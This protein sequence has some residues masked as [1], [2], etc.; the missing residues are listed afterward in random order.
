MH[1][2]RSFDYARLPNRSIRDAIAI[3]K[4]SLKIVTA[5]WTIVYF[6]ILFSVVL[7]DSRWLIGF[8]AEPLFILLYLH[9][10]YRCP[11]QV[12][13]YI[14]ERETLSLFSSRVGWQCGCCPYDWVMKVQ[15]VMPSHTFIV[16]YT[17][18][19]WWPVGH[20][21]SLTAHCTA[22]IHRLGDSCLGDVRH[23]DNNATQHVVN[24]NDV[25][26]WQLQQW[27][28]IHRCA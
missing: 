4:S 3:S 22:D 27:I 26:T 8:E 20:L 23:G 10:Y 15:A 6:F 2:N 28:C 5:L 21:H 24:D 25:W 13:T 12:I 11:T 7:L 18:K 19:H 17:G 1:E 14:L 16:M 9:L